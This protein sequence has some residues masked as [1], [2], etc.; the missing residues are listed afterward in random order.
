[1]KADGRPMMPWSN[2]LIWESANWR[3][4]MKGLWVLD[5]GSFVSLSRSEDDAMIE[6]WCLRTLNR[7]CSRGG[8]A[9]NVDVRLWRGSR[10]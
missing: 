1:M 7:R 9:M 4:L 3:N 2:E 6:V 5:G 10:A 8:S